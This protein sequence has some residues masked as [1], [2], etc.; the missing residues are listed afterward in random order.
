MVTPGAARAG[1]IPERKTRVKNR[2]ENARV[3]P[4]DRLFLV[5]IMIFSSLPSVYGIVVL[6]LARRWTTVPSPFWTKYVHVPLI[7]PVVVAGVRAV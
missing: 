3:N 2:K 5:P 6:V 1:T 7:V 4:F